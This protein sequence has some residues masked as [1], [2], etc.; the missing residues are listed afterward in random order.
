MRRNKLLEA[1]GVTHYA[2]WASSKT[3]GMT[4]CYFSTDHPLNNWSLTYI[5]NPAEM[6]VTCMACLGKINY[7]GEG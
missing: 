4:I 1:T 2:M 5:D 6:P 3:G 7:F